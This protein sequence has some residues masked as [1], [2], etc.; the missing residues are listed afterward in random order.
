MHL[1][2]HTHFKALID[3]QTYIHTYIYLFFMHSQIYFKFFHIHSFYS[4]K[5]ASTLLDLTFIFIH[6]LTHHS[7]P[8]PSL[9]IYT[10]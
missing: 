6:I 7:I 5:Y 1:Y 4:F 10:K 9:C 2:S 3:F 8:T